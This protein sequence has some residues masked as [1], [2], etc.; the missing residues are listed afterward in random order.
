VL[1]ADANQTRSIEQLLATPSGALELVSAMAAHEPARSCPPE[2]LRRA[3]NHPLFQVRDLFERFLP[4]EMRPKKLGANPKP[5][6]ILTL[7]GDVSNGENIFF[8]EGTQCARCHRIAGRG[9]EFGPDLSLIGRKYSAG[10]L[11]EQILTPS[12]SIDP[13]YVSYQ[14]ETK[15]DLS[16]TGFVL[17]RSSEEI[18]LKDSNLNVVKIPTAEIRQLQTQQLSAMP[19][20]LLQNMTPQEAADLIAFLSQQR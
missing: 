1:K 13:A 6:S 14:V 12:K 17:H 9:R 20:G 3:A 2:L 16:Y 8:R 5:E 11:L 19:E 15:H 10:Q 18:L 4:D 7:K